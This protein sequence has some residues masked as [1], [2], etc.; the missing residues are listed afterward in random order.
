MSK[1]LMLVDTAVTVPVNIYP[2]TDDTDFKSREVGIVYNQAGMDLVWNFVTK[3]G[4]I[5]QTAVTPTTGGDYDWTH[6]GDGM[7][8]IEIPASSGASI[9][10]D[11]EGFGW[12]TGICT[13]VL[14][15][16]GPIIQFSPANVVNAIV[17]GSDKLEVDAVEI[18]SVAQRATDLAEIS[19]YLFANAATLTSIL[20][21]DSVVAKIIATGGTVSGFDESNDSL[22]SI[23]DRIDSGFEGI[24]NVGA[25]VNRPASSYTLTTGV[26]SSGTVSDT[27][28]LDGTNHEHTDTAGEMD[29]YYEFSIGSGL[30][31]SVVVTGYLNSANDSLEVYGWDWVASAWV[32]IG[33]LVGKALSTNEINS[34]DLFINMVGTGADLG[35]VRIRFTDGAFTLTTATLAI[36][37]IFVSYSPG[38]SGYENGSLWLDTNASNTNTVVGV[39]GTATNPVSTI[40]AI[41]TL[42][43]ATGLRKVTVAPGSSFTMAS[44]FTNF[45]F[46]GENWT[47]AL[48]GQ[49]IPGTHIHGAD[50][51]GVCTGATEPS[52]EQC[53]FGN[54][55][56]PPCHLSQCGFEGTITLGL[57][58]T[59]FFDDCHSAIA[60]VS[61]PV[62]DY[63]AALNASSVNMRRYSGGVEIRNM[64]AGTGSYNMSLEGFGQ[65]I[66]NANCS[67][68]STVAIRG[69]FTITDNAGGAVT[70]SNE[71]MFDHNTTIDDILADVT[72][73]NGDAMRGTD[74]ANTTVPDA[75]GVAAGLHTT[76]DALIS[77][78]ADFDPST[79]PVEILA[80][81][82]SAGK[83]AEELVDD[84]WDELLTAATHNIATSAGRRLRDLGHDIIITGTSPDTGGVAN[85]A[86][87]IEL[88]S[89]AS[90]VD[91]AYDP[92]LVCI[93]SGT[94][95][96]QTRQIFEYD[97]TNRYAY[98]N[99]DWKTIP[100]NTSGYAIIG[101]S[102]NTHVNEGLAAGGSNNTIT[103]N[104]LASS[105]SGTY[106]GQIAFISAGT[107]QDQA[108][109]ITAYDGSTKIATVES[110]WD[111]NPDT[112]SIYA[113]LPTD[114]DNL[115]AAISSRSTFDATSDPVANVTLVDTV[116]TNT[117][118]RGTDNAALAS[119]CTEGRLS[120][121]DAANI[122]AD[123]DAI[124]VKTDELP[125]LPKKNVA[126]NNFSFFMADETDNKTGETG[127]TITSLIR[128]DSGAFAPT[129]NSATEVSNGFYEID[130]TAEE[131]NADI[132]I[133]TFSAT[134]A[135]TKSFTLMLAT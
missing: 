117:D 108:R 85:T 84:V 60:G 32:Q 26:Q 46:L 81:G 6:S 44:T 61:S 80:T 111:T 56:L 71:A 15:W 20:A 96:G 95:A 114:L 109:L 19:Q 83:N 2:L 50:V 58:G 89:G 24:A 63:G 34:Y 62:L 65:L 16:A 129:V 92:A 4:V 54:V 99:R 113:I 97:G 27:E 133:V 78:L 128:K 104:S 22:Q 72:G 77:G 76:T 102:G 47:L 121:L 131:M 33:T 40:A 106:V 87:R 18:D 31:I 112:G 38:T 25:A 39:D 17:D 74:G 64:G 45:I 29:L 125:A 35:K 73:L 43:A 11:A 135:N 134:G 132:V 68:T 93:T 122:P 86:I 116:T 53:H 51:S 94:G 28:A 36:D 1:I 21:D 10:N 42:A 107:G 103:L 55:T 98:V 105:V 88:E 3:A 127:L 124:K 91:G 126:L 37:Q 9:N 100:D 79:T 70:F 23:R 90:S 13:G 119:V 75:A 130:F 5:T 52:F 7:Y 120:E 49:D 69:H 118:M 8:K 57:A 110:N 30:P 82:G 67:A 14:A 123:I 12:F 115:D 41:V 59:F 101:H 66:I 48:G